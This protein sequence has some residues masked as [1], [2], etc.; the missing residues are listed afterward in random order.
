MCVCVRTHARACASLMFCCGRSSGKKK[1]HKHK[2]FCPVGLGTNPGFL[3]ILHSGSP[4]NPGLSLGQTQF[5][6]L[7]QCR[8]RR[9]AQKVYV[10]NVYVPFFRADLCNS[11]NEGLGKDFYRKGNS[12][13]RFGPFAEPPD[14][15]N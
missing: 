2:L 5:V 13:K 3:L 8:G 9:A 11:V 4:A 15:E 7:G 10:K 12:V 6:P 1:A 14:S